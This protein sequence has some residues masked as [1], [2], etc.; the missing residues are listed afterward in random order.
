MNA[1]LSNTCTTGFKMSSTEKQSSLTGQEID[2][3]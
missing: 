3:K 1:S 2:G